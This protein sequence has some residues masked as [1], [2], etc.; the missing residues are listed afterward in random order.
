MLYYLAVGFYPNFAVFLK[1][2][3]YTDFGHNGKEKALSRA[4]EAARKDKERTFGV[5]CTRSHILQLSSCF[6]V[7]KIG[8]MSRMCVKCCIT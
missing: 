4:Q 1:C 3:S 7:V 6:M 5:L 2:F 8:R